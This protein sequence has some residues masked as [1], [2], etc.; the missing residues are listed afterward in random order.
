MGT[1]T[2]RRVLD[3]IAAHKRL[4]VAARKQVRPLETFREKCLPA[5]SGLLE[6]AFRNAVGGTKLMLE[7]KPSSPS[8]GVLTAA[9]DLDSVLTAY[10]QAGVAVS[11]LTDEKYFGGSL[12][13]LSQVVQQTALPVL[14]KDFILDAYQI[15]EA[16]EAGASA[17]LLIVKMLDDIALSE[18]TALSRQLGMTPLIEIQDEE[19]LQR[20]LAVSPPILLINNRDLQSLA[21]DL[22]TTVR[23]SSKIPAGILKVSASGIGSRADIERLQPYCDG[24]LIGSV[25][26]KQ[27]LDQLSAKLRELCGL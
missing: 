11:V 18:L 26:M 10:A 15:Y 14:R 27:P 23:L 8:A 17:I 13:L 20:A 25:L 12:D 16:R 4:E 21:I 1:E 7:I 6:T 5:K 3:E 22:Q 24:F 19:E 2:S 9:L